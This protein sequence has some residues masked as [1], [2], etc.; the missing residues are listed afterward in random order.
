[1][2]YDVAVI[3]GGP[4]GLMAAGRAGELGAKVV[5]LEK[6]KY[7]GRKLL[8]TGKGRCNITNAI[9]NNRELVAKYGKNGKFLYSAFNKFNVDDTLKFFEKFG[10]ATKVERGQRVFPVSDRSYDVLQALI[11]YNKKGKVEIKTKSGVKKIVVKKKIIEKIILENNEEII[12][13][14]YILSTGGKSYPA[15][16]CTGD[17]YQWLKNNGHTIVKPQPAL[18]PIRLEERFV[19]DLEGL[20]LKNVEI[21]LY[22]NNKKI[23]SRFGEALFTADGMSG[24]IILDISKKVGEELS[25]DL[26]LKIDFKPA[27]DFKQLDTRI[28]R[29]FS[30]N[31]N[32][33][34]ANVAKLLLPNKLIPVVLRVS[35]IE[36]NKKVCLITKEERVKLIHVLKTFNLQII[37]LAGFEQAIVTSGGLSLDEIDPK[38]M[39]S[40]II[41]NLYL[42]G[43][44][45]DIDGPTG[46]FNLQVCWSTG[47]LVGSSI[48]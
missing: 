16:G 10:V 20:S 25:A 37:G 29:D 22:K 35:S 13:N 39:Q 31:S 11:D 45:I 1:M 33:N 4:A 5:L 30:Q 40:R 7:L 44:I 9:F 34:I 12:A 26:N 18:V 41:H 42:A 23:D 8:I 15:T 2:K 24:P 3:G 47:Y 36:K 46:G 28:Q 14:K 6:N 38:T 48:I 27:L 32:K 17:G 43:E 19:K 21:S